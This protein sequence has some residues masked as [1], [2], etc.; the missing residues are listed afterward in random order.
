MNLPVPPAGFLVVAVLSAAAAAV[1]AMVVMSGS[2]LL[3]RRVHHFVAVLRIL[4]LT[5]LVLALLDP[6]LKSSLPDPSAYRV[7][8][9]ADVSRSMETRDLPGEVS[10]LE[11]LSSWLQP[12][13]GSPRFRQLLDEATPVNVRLFSSIAR[14]WDGQ[15]I[16]QPLPGQ[17]AIGDALNGLYEGTRSSSANPLGGVLLLSDGMS[18][19]GPPPVEAARRFNQAGIPVS[20]IGIGKA[21]DTGDVTIGFEKSVHRLEEGEDGEVGIYL[22]NTFTTPR[23][24]R[25]TVYQDDQILTER[26]V[27]ME[28]GQRM[29]TRVTV[30][31]SAPGVETLRATFEPAFTGDNP[32]T[33][34]AFSIAEIKRA[35]HYRFLLLADSGG[36]SER[37][38][39]VLAS[40][41]S[42]FAMDSLIRIDTERYFLNQQSTEVD[43]DPASPIQRETLKDLPDSPEFYR[44]YDALILDDVI[45]SKNS[46]QLDPVLKEF[47]GT[48]GGGVLLIHSGQG[49]SGP[50]ELPSSLR[51]LFPARDVSTTFIQVPSV[52]KF[53]GD[54]LFADLLGGVLFTEPSPLL[55]APALVGRPNELSR[56]AQ[57]PIR[58]QP[59]NVPVLVTHAYGAGRSAWLATDVFWR[60]KIGNERSEAQYTALWEALFSWLAVGGKDRLETPVNATIV[61]MDAPVDLRIRALG[62]DYTPRMDASVTALLTGPDGHSRTIRLLPSIDEPGQYT[63]ADILDQPGTWRVD[64]AVLFPDGDELRETAWFAM[65]ATSRES[66]ETAFEEKLLRDM[67]RLGGGVYRSF[68]DWSELTPLPVS[69]A[70]PLVED[71]VHW[72]RTW[73]FLIVAF[74]FFVAEWWLRRR[75]GLR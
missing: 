15:P 31:P 8:V 26:E 30:N 29:S 22:E 59:G 49:E 1:I 14:P 63:H 16:T 4:G 57:A 39:R 34:T 62:Q 56:A 69:N 43:N 66:R 58:G 68:E 72:T 52:L 27:S 46:T 13:S 75:H 53:E 24:G 47:V 54:S 36:W 41:S 19:S 17:T 51:N 42:S 23:D 71:R 74:T 18:L 38:L 28:A 61:P 20:V 3:P 5:A 40:E 55:P 35:D 6:F 45:L 37:I 25:L 70:I 32:A 2:S 12:E 60:W 21:T 73:P 10:R 67:A 44:A 11:W 7:A 48:Q 33:N 50:Q 65:A 64:Y 9:L